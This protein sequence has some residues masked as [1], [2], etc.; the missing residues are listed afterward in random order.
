LN[1]K[2]KL[3]LHFNS[4]LA[5]QRAAAALDEGE[6]LVVDG[7]GAVDGDVDVGVGVQGGQRDAQ[8][9]CL[10]LGADR[11]GDGNDVLVAAAA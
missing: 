6:R 1:F 5:Q 8:A 10:L 11:R 4:L 2:F 7:V 3:K 9:L